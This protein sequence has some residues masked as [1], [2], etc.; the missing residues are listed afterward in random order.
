MDELIAKLNLE[1]D[2]LEK[3]LEN[4]E[5][6]AADNDL[7]EV[8]ED[9][10]VRSYRTADGALINA[11]IDEDFGEDMGFDDQTEWYTDPE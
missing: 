11:W 10:A 4:L 7:T 2:A 1:F 6:V 3:T 9:G 8:Y 5:T